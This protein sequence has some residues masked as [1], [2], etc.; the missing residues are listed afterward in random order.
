MDVEDEAFV[1]SEQAEV[2]DSRGFVKEEEEDKEDYIF[3]ITPAAA[4]GVDTLLFLGENLTTREAGLV[5]NSLG[6]LLQLEDNDIC[7]YW[8]ASNAEMQRKPRKLKVIRKLR[9]EL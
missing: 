4:R 2:S 7:V 1:V 8:E 6:E 9:G 3:A 5:M